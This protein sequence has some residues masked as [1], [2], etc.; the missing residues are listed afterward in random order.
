MAAAQCAKS[1]AEP[2]EQD[3]KSIFARFIDERQQ[4][5]GATPL[6]QQQKDELFGQFEQWQKGQAR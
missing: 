5:T 2:N 4:A 6:T 1:P 3:L